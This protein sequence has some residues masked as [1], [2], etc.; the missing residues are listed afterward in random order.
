VQRTQRET[1]AVYPID[2]KQNFCQS[3]SQL[4]KVSEEANK[5]CWFPIG[6]PFLAQTISGLWPWPFRVTWRHPSRDHKTRSV[7]FAMSRDHCS[8]NIW[9]PIGGP[10]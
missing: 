3:L 9:F 7:W 4:V 1:K 10:L 5:N 8:Q 2:W 6:G